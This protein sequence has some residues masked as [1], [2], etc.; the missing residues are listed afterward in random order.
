MTDAAPIA[1]EGEHIAPEAN[2]EA[3]NCPWCGVLARQVWTSLRYGSGPQVS[4]GGALR[5]TCTNCRK[6]SIWVDTRPEGP[7]YA[8]QM[9][10]PLVGGG[11]RPHIDMPTDVKVDYDEARQIVALSPRGACALLRLALQKLCVHL[12]EPG[13]NINDDIKSLVAS[14]LPAEVQQAL[15][16]LRIVGNNAV[17]PGEMDLTDDVATAAG[18]F[19][20][21]NFIVQDRIAQPKAI[22]SMYAALPQGARDAVSRRDGTGGAATP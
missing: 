19:T 14:G 21:L 10:F 6:Y 13:K 4:D 9:V 8:W 3:F 1:R 12:G 11:P 7:G 5:C 20:V 18:L 2:R 17:H 22:K 16:T 15:D